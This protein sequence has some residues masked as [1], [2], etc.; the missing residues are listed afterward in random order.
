MKKNIFILLFLGL[1]AFSGSAQN[2]ESLLKEINSQADS[3]RVATYGLISEKYLRSQTD[4]ALYYAN[5]QLTLAL[6]L[7]NKKQQMYGEI[8]LGFAY[9]YLGEYEPSLE[10]HFNALALARELQ[11]SSAEASYLSGIATMY[12]RMDNYEQSESYFLQSIKL[13]QDNKDTLSLA[14]SYINYGNLLD[15]MDRDEESLQRYRQALEIYESKKDSS[16]ITLAIG[17]IGALL[18]NERRIDEAEP[19]IHQGITLAKAMKD[20]LSELNGMYNLGLI[21]ELRKEFL[22][23]EALYKQAYDLAEAIQLP[24]YMER[25]THGR[26]RVLA[27]AGFYEKAYQF[28][29]EAYFLR[30]SM[31]QI[32]K[33]EALAELQA[34]FE[35]AEKDLSISN[36]E[37]LNVMEALRNNQL[38][39]WIIGL[40]MLLIMLALIFGLYQIRQQRL[41]DLAFRERENA[42]FR[43]VLTG[44]EKERKRIANDLHDSL[45]QLLSA[46]KM[47]LSSIGPQQEEFTN[48]RLTT[49]MSMID[50]SVKEV[51]QISHNL[52]P[53]ALLT[54]D[55]SKA[56]RDL[57]RMIQNTRNVEVNL[58][59]QDLTLLP[60]MEMHLF[61]IIQELVNNSL[62]HSGAKLIHISASQDETHIF[63]SISDNGKGFNPQD[64]LNNGGGL[65]WHSIHGRVKIMNGDIEVTSS[66]VTGT[67]VSLTFKRQL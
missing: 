1:L 59:L 5:Q 9:K 57:G 13:K 18:L 8:H 40:S 11:R 30:D 42:Q 53:P 46:T 65:G 63:A 67:S 21:E 17:N 28:E 61:R 34:E 43:A 25:L 12:K 7:G 4:S 31:F 36:L 48:S 29:R 41:K 26:A 45:G 22:A 6:K 27:D 52:A 23:A 35:V 58:D 51:R 16:S 47:Q 33:A 32:D 55:L 54:G 64:T 14:H 44:E 15:A 10:H 37:K 62:K 24:E 39:S 19:Y 60:E 66:Q 20:Q 2:L 56:I 38:W 49:A 50:E 3:L